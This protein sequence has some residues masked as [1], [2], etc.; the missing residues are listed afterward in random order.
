MVESGPLPDIIP[1]SRE[2]CVQQVNDGLQS[3]KYLLT[4]AEVNKS[5]LPVDEWQSS[6]NA[7]VATTCSFLKKLKLIT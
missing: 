4:L 1:S 5:T 2:V 6:M 3:I 7:Q